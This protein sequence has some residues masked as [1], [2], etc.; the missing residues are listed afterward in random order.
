MRWFRVL[1]IAELLRLLPL[2]RR[3]RQ[4]QIG[5]GLDGEDDGVLN[6]LRFERWTWRDREDR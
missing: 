3:V 4:G 1:W 6:L 5:G 2:R